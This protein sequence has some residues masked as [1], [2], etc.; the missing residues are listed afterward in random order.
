MSTVSRQPMV[1][2]I[3]VASGWLLDGVTEVNDL[4]LISY[5]GLVNVEVWSHGSQE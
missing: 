3:C 4:C 2:L 5:L 1:S